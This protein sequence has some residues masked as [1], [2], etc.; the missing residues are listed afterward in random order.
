MKLSTSD[1]YLRNMADGRIVVSVCRDCGA[2]QAM[3][4]ESCFNCGGASLE[5]KPH[6]GAGEIFSWVT[7]HYVFADGLAS[8]ATYVVAL[9]ELEGGARIYGRLESGATEVTAGMGVAF[10][11]GA[12]RKSGFPV[13]RPVRP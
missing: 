5:A 4:S 11:A 10:D 12:T 13:F 9:V 6:S 1:A 7:N 2:Q 8:E 3:P